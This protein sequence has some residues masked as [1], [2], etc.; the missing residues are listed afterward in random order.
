MSPNQLS[1][2]EKLQMKKQLSSQLGTQH[3]RKMLSSY[4]LNPYLEARCPKLEL[5]SF[6][7]CAGVT[8]AAVERLARCPLLRSVN[9][10]YCGSLTEAATV[11]HAYPTAS[12]RR[13]LTDAA[14]SFLAKSPRIQSVNF[15]HCRNLTDGAP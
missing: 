8:D 15:A 13:A 6:Q 12:Q 11:M 2:K 4:R 10:A 14:A 3:E 7:S 1:R 5:V 9:F